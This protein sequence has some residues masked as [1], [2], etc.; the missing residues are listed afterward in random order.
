MTDEVGK[1]DDGA[2][3]PILAKRTTKLVDAVTALAKPV[4][5]SF[6]LELD[7]VEMR[8][9]G[10]RTV[11]QVFIDKP[12]GVTHQDCAH[13]S[14]QLS[15]E[16]DIHDFIPVAYDLEVSSPGLDRPLFGEADFRRFAGRSA[17]VTCRRAVEGVGSKVTG[18]LRGLEEGSVLVELKGGRTVRIPLEMVAKARLE[19]EI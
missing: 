6:G 1:D 12:G 7:R 14:R 9:A 19:P 16:L 11:L 18:T 2:T 3:A 4:A 17:S 15:A 8:Q 13:V 10:R 5:E